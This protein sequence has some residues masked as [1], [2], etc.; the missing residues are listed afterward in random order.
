MNTVILDLDN[1]LVFVTDKPIK[2]YLADHSFPFTG[3]EGKMILHI[4]KRPFLDFFIETISK[5][6][7]L[8]I[9]SNS[10]CMYLH[11]VVDILF[12]DIHFVQ[13]ISRE[14]FNTLPE[15]HVPNLKKLAP[16]NI[17]NVLF[18]DDSPDYITGI[19][20]EQVIP[21]IPFWGNP[22]DTFLLDILNKFV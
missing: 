9:W 20:K 10:Y 18:L 13:V 8:I 15:K 6:Y 14:T 7:K 19:K 2:N 17:N 22:A 5:R 16:I 4:Y 21:A 1:T 12:K 3:P 11:K